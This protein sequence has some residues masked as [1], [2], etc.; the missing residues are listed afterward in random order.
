[1]NEELLVP[2]LKKYDKLTKE[3]FYPGYYHGYIWGKQGI[4]EE[5]Y[6][7][8]IKDITSF[9]SRHVAVQPRPVSY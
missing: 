3:K 2:V 1:M 9:C 5:V 8:I 6:R 4:P 7:T